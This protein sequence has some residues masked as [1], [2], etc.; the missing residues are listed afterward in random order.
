MPPKAL[1]TTN[2]QGFFYIRVMAIPSF[3]TFRQLDL[4]DQLAITL[5]E[6]TFLATRFGEEGDTINLYH[7]GSFFA[8]VYYDPEV[9]YLHH[10]RSFVSSGPLEHYTEYV[11]LPPLL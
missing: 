6:G 7:M 9:N 3:Y 11:K 8:E 10:C 4:T 5:M 2:G 1:T